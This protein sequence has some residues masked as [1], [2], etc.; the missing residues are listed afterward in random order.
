MLVVACVYRYDDASHIV[1]SFATAEDR[2]M[3]ERYSRPV[4]RRQSLAARALLRVSLSRLFDRPPQSW[5]LSHSAS[6]KPVVRT[7][8]GS[9]VAKISISHS[10]G[11][12]ACAISDL[13]SIG[14]DVEYCAPGRRIVNIAEMTFGEAELAAVGRE[15]SAAFYKIWTLREAMAKALGLGVVNMAS[16]SD[17]FSSAPVGKAWSVSVKRERWT[18]LHSKYLRNYSLSIALKHE[19]IA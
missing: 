15:G 18:F 16:Q 6:G 10:R 3:C 5:R 11:L 4:R 17:L 13:G 9:E 19:H 1:S 2:R 14:I 12:V 8:S 7:S